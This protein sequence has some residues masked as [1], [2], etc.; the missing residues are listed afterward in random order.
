MSNR[1]NSDCKTLFKSHIEKIDSKIAD[2]C[3]VIDKKYKLFNFSL[4]D[5]ASKALD[6]SMKKQGKSPIIT[7]KGEETTVS[8]LEKDV[9][10]YKT[11]FNNMRRK[12][13]F[14]YIRNTYIREYANAIKTEN[15]TDRLNEAY[16]KCIEMINTEES[17]AKEYFSICSD[18][19]KVVTKAAY[20]IINES[21]KATTE[22]TNN[23]TKDNT[24][25]ARLNK[26]K[27]EFMVGKQACSRYLL[28]KGTKVSKSD[29]SKTI[30]SKMMAIN[31]MIDKETDDSTKNKFKSYTNELNKYLAKVKDNVTTYGDDKGQEK[32]DDKGTPLKNANIIINNAI[33]SARKAMRNSDKE[34][35]QKA[36]ADGKK[37]IED[38]KK[39]IAKKNLTPSMKTSI[40]VSISKAMTGLTELSKKVDRTK[41]TN[42][43]VKEGIECM[44]NIDEMLFDSAMEYTMESSIVEKITGKDSAT[45]KS[46]ETLA[47][48]GKK[49]KEYVASAKADAKAGKFDAAKRT[50]D[51]AIKELEG[52]DK[53]LSSLNVTAKD[54]NYEQLA[55]TI[56]P[57]VTALAVSKIVDSV[58][59]TDTKA[60]PLYNLVIAKA[61]KNYKI[62]K[63]IK[64]SK[65]GITAKDIT[66]CI[67]S[68]RSTISDYIKT[69]NKIKADI[70]K[71][72]AKSTKEST[73]LDDVDS[74]IA[75]AYMNGDLSD[76]EFLSLME[77]TEEEIVED[78]LTDGEKAEKIAEAIKEETEEDGSSEGD[79]GEG[80]AE[81]TTECGDPE[82]VATLQKAVEDGIITD[83]QYQAIIKANCCDGEECEGEACGGSCGVGEE[84]GE[85]CPGCK[86]SPCVCGPESKEGCCKEGDSECDGECDGGECEG[87]PEQ[88]EPTADPE[89]KDNDGI[90]DQVIPAEDNEDDED[91]DDDQEFPLDKDEYN[92]K[93]NELY[94]M[95]ANDK[96][97]LEE[98]EAKLLEL[99]EAYSEYNKPTYKTEEEAIK[100][101]KKRGFETDTKKRLGPNRFGKVHPVSK[102]VIQTAFVK[103]KANGEY[104]ITLR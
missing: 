19:F 97:T 39:S 5:K 101:L 60:E 6:K 55:T 82:I 96:I 67:G 94:Q 92:N 69:L 22:A 73:E 48:C 27:E 52:A 56:A 54:V 30:V 12:N 13:Y 46:K 68:T 34:T 76:D 4:F 57:I 65:N 93:C 71:K 37:K 85:V 9:K 61:I 103:R 50:I 33:S 21:T 79:D 8:K 11:S 7:V 64:R 29:A 81:E 35:A 90:L 28:S 32:T 16:K 49:F 59:G 3:N 95:C 10:T 58:F 104:E 63:V 99:K 17:K 42:K 72:A 36:I 2:V 43:P 98:R 91:D 87:E 45:V 18:G 47:D 24:L 89:D 86:Q 1:T 53:E 77:G 44:Y 74:M 15:C 41:V 66:T 78:D 40:N 80:D 83:D 88:V 26:A 84:S 51:N 75:E 20:K 100:A 38:L 62:L 31:K 102:K 14:A 70:D 23:D 25:Q